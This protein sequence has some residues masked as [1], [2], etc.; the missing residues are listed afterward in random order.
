M[1]ASVASSHG[2]GEASSPH[3]LHKERGESP[4]K[5]KLELFLGNKPVSC[6]IENIT[7]LAS[8]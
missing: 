7:H 3:Q 6:I 4:Q 2:M 5:A 1:P 8:Y